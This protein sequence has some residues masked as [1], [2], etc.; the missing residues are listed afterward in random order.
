MVVSDVSMLD[1]PPLRGNPFDL[2]PIERSRAEDIVARGEILTVWREHM[3]S[4]S[5]R[6]LL[7]VGE[8]G[9]GRT[10][11]INVL[12]S[13]TTRHFV[14]QYWH[15]ENPLKRVLSEIS[16]TFGGHT[17]PQTM[18]QTVE[19]LV[20]TLD[21][22]DGPLPLI[23]LD[24]PSNVD[25]TP[26]LT[27]IAPILQRLRALVVVALTNAQLAAL[28]EPV[29]ALFDKPVHL[30]PL[31]SSQI[32]S[33]ADNRVRRMARE[34]WPI[35]LRLLDSV[36]ASTGGNPRDVIHLLRDLI[37]EKRGTGAEGTFER[38]LGWNA[39][40]K[41]EPVQAAI[42]ETKIEEKYEP[43]EEPQ[44]P[45]SVEEDEIE[46]DWDVEP[47]DMW[48]DEGLESGEDAEPDTEPREEDEE[49]N[50]HHP[51]EQGDTE[52][53]RI[54]DWAPEKG[55]FM[56]ME[57]GTEPPPKQSRSGGFSGLMGR[58][59]QVSDHMPTGTDDTPITESHTPSPPSITPHDF[60]PE[61]ANPPKQ[62][63]AP[64]S[65]DTSTTS[66]A[67]SPVFATEGELWTVDSDLEDT[68]PEIPDDPLEPEAFDTL[69]PAFEEEFPSDPGIVEE[70][71]PTYAPVNI[72]PRWESADALDEAHL[73]S[74]SD[75]ERLVVSIAGQREI[76]PSDT[77]IQARL[78]VG[79]PRLSQIY[80]A[81]QRS[82][83]LS[84]RK[85]GRSR[86]FKLSDAAAEMLP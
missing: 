86:L 66:T 23:A 82:G 44:L 9:S 47:D 35:N 26:F 24:Y 74:M 60:E 14:S 32:Q 73:G 15:D 85:E 36:R 4:Q 17:V 84:A 61:P 33:L 18:H 10:S 64:K 29:Q 6:M 48:G 40:F 71:P 22:E 7:I 62:R 50:V 70:A 39:P 2:R 80:N 54:T 79:R 55:G 37:D 63:T 75:A 78:E 58:S 13:Q 30:E 41:P 65:I 68:L 31:T 77:E 43:L 20:E 83:I 21:I 25:I 67:E 12:S 46:D 52:P 49:D 45:V 1:I 27:L 81:L 51:A 11:L 72:G 38:L 34:K 53:F 59:R 28:E 76:S 16:V 5:P 3:H 8:R 19:Q 57:E 42:V 69:E 56:L